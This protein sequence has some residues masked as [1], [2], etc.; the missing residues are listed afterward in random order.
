MNIVFRGLKVIMTLVFF[1][2]VTCS[3]IA[4]SIGDFVYRLDNNNLTAV[5][6][7][8]NIRSGD[9]IIP[10]SVWYNNKTY[11]V[12]E[13]DEDAIYSDYEKINIGELYIPASITTINEGAFQ[14]ISSVNKMV[15]EDSA[16]PLFMKFYD[17]DEYDDYSY[18]WSIGTLILG[19]DIP[20]SK[21][22]GRF[23]FPSTIS[24]V[25]IGKM[26]SDISCCLLCQGLSASSFD[27][28][29]PSFVIYN[30]AVY[31]SDKT[32]LLRAFNPSSFSIS[33]NT[34]EI[35]PAAFY[36]CSNMQGKVSISSG[37]TSVGSYAFQGCS[38][39]TEV[40][41]SENVETV[42]K[43][44]FSSCTNLQT[45]SLP[46][47][48]SHLPAYMF[49][50]CCNL[51]AITLPAGVVSIGDQAFDFGTVK[52]YTCYAT[53]PP[54]FA[55][56]TSIGRANVHVKRGYKNVYSQADV[57][58]LG[59]IVEDLVLVE[60]TCGESATWYFEK[61]GMLT[62]AG[63]GSMNDYNGNQTI[64][65]YNYLG[66]LKSAV[67]KDGIT[68]IGK[69]SFFNFTQL[70]DIRIGKDVKSIGGLAFYGTALR[71][72]TLPDGLVS[73]GDHAFEGCHNLQQ[74]NIP[75]SVTEFGDYAFNLSNTSLP[76]IDGLRYADTY[77]V[78]AVDKT[79]TTAQ[80]KEGTRFIGRGAFEYC[81][82]L[83]DV[84]IPESV[85]DI[86]GFAFN[87]CSSLKKIVIPKNVKAIK[88]KA[89]VYCNKLFFVTCLS[90]QVPTLENT[91]F[92]DYT[93]QNGVLSVPKSKIDDYKS[94]TEWKDF[95]T[96]AINIPRGD[97]NRDGDISIADLPTMI[98]KIN[99][100]NDTDSLLKSIPSLDA[101]G[102]GKFDN[103]DI[104]AL[105]NYLLSH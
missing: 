72:V 13:I 60:G 12:T 45:I 73:I 82:C 32:K 88:E 69:T 99:S 44:A 28:Q 2:C 46:N 89:F 64:P 29:N 97:T 95:E 52:D 51:T 76:V 105:S 57:W 16:T 101:N 77:L 75:Q 96:I 23:C 78:E 10:S 86:L 58:N 7:G 91:V 104:S 22:E 63:S 59:T 14:G 41:I 103:S 18:N 54:T 27:E 39:I 47:C 31:N 62:I 81:D 61:D 25:S 21:I 85:T 33:S 50:N 6:T 79:M 94:A 4:E 17:A 43:Y 71:S 36:G 55:E 65:W 40:S 53:T 9:M 68:H 3:A 48:L 37:I 35:G 24:N 66:S 19:R 93:K 30:K 56:W 87:G 74:I 100:G 83:T 49:Y 11:R 34:Q 80:I 92:N 90:N 84:V 98:D 42:G 102:D 15:I 70:V 20:Y 8:T 67:I 26:V 5:I 38:N 1:A